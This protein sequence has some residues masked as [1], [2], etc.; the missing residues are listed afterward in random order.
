[1]KKVNYRYYFFNG[2]TVAVSS[3]AGKAVR[4]VSKC[5]PRDTYNVEYGK[6]LAEKRCDYKVAKRR[7]KWASDRLIEL[8]ECQE[9]INKEYKRALEY[10]NKSIDELNETK[11]ALE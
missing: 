6:Q 9:Y 10:Y 2:K 7:H 4:G 3:F 5:D 8:A 11:K 1:M